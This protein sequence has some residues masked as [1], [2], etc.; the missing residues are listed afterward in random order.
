MGKYPS[1]QS[2]QAQIRRTADQNKKIHLGSPGC[3]FFL[4]KFVLG[5]TKCF[6]NSKELAYQEA[7][8][9]LF[10]SV[11]NGKSLV[12][13]AITDKGVPTASDATFQQMA[14]NINSL[15]L[16]P[17]YTWKKYSAIYNDPTTIYTW[18]KYNYS[19]TYNT[20]TGSSQSA[21]VYGFDYSL[22]GQGIANSY[23]VSGA[24][25]ILNDITSNVYAFSS[26]LSTGCYIARFSNYFGGVNAVTR[27]Y[28]SSPA[29]TIYHVTSANFS[30]STSGKI[31]Y[32]ILTRS[33]SNVRDDFIE[34]V[35]S[36][37]NDTYPNNGI[38]NG[39]W[40][41]YIGS[42][43]SEGYYSQGSYIEDITSF[44]STE[45]PANGYQNGYWYVLQ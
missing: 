43:T 8:D 41:M 2:P 26:R 17:L 36:S 20:N 30:S 3:I 23:T 10:T 1:T 13:S 7:V 31:T 39:Y 37:A 38:Q 40:Y 9:E 18:G 44:D 4:L 29:S 24:N 22:S 25:F 6:G 35:T 34:N 33:S 27:Y 45:Y 19:T 12:A 42:E 32:Q 16:A 5:N 14:D 28:A 11:S 21:N 15:V